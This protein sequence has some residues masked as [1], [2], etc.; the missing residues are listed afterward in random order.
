MNFTYIILFI[1]VKLFANTIMHL[2][3]YSLFRSLMSLSMRGQPWAV[4]HHKDV[5][6]G[7]W[8]NAND[9]DTFLLNGIGTQT[10]VTNEIYLSSSHCI[11][12]IESK[13]ARKYYY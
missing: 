10:F 11:F 8:F 13:Q 9:D 3:V 2:T 12:T 1:H 4:R 6:G 7:W 5:R